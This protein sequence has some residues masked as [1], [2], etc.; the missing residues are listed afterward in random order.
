MIEAFISLLQPAILIPW[1]LAM[2]LGVF[3]GAMPGLTATMGVALIVP[4]TFHM[5]P[6][7]GLAM[8]LGLSFT[9]IFAG[10]IPADRKSVV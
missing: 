5:Q 4:L 8:I 7:A 3:I 2:V 6:I 9:A 10:D 1:I